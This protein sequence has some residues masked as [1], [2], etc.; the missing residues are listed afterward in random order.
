MKIQPSKRHFPYQH[1]TFGSIRNPKPET[2]WKGTVYYWWWAYLKRS[3]RYIA[4]CERGGTGELSDL[5][6]DFG[7]VRGDNFK[8][9]W[10]ED[11]RGLR[12]FAEPRGEDSV[13][14]L[15]PEDQVLSQSEA[16][17]VSLPLYLPRRHL[18]RAFKQLL[19]QAHPGK[20]GIQLA[21][22][23]QA[24]YRVQGQPN[25][26]ALQRGLEVYD[27]WKSSKEPL[28]KIGNDLPGIIRTQKIKPAE[29][30]GEEMLKRRALAATVRRYISRVEQTIECVEQGILP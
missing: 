17:T 16:L 25:T 22:H 21:K 6:A 4:C 1:P 19:A 14:I 23:S 20:R 27:R 18:E 2:A 26:K 9:W 8:Q 11:S 15:T 28:W 29:L 7:D 24:R 12:L 13:R 5:Y 3:E 10:L 30:K